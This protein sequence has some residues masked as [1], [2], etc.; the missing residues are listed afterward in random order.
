M[1]QSLPSRV[2]CCGAAGGKTRGLPMKVSNRLAFATAIALG[3]AVPASATHSW[4]NY[5]W[6]RISNPFALRVNGALSSKW[7][8]HANTAMADWAKS[9]VLNFT[10]TTPFPSAASRK[11]CNPIAGQILVC[12]ELYG[13]RGWLGIASI[14]LNGSHITQATTKLNDTYFNMTRYNTSAWRQ[15]VACQEIGHDFGLA[16]QDENFYNA[17]LGT[18]M[19]YT[20]LPGTNQHPNQHDYDQLVKIYSHTDSFN[21]YKSTAA[22]TNFG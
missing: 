19:D 1:R 14:W 7:I 22:A 8:P 20:N 12:N 2:A 9:T 13:Q 21:S 5:H 15:L 18:C 3:V 4:G 17:N 11:Q 10:S 16:H 6:A